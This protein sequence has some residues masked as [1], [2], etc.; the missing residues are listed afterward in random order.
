MTDPAMTL[1]ADMPLGTIVA[2]SEAALIKEASNLW[3]MTGDMAARTDAAIDQ[4]ISDGDA[5]V[6]RLGSQV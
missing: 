6:I 4:G 2:T 3:W 1:A 5:T